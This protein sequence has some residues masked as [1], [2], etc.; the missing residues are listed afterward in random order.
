MRF[1]DMDGKTEV[2]V[3]NALGQKVDVITVDGKSGREV[4]YRMP[5]VPNGLYYLVMKSEK[6]MVIRKLLLQR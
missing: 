5:D 2:Q 1:D 4:D 3:F 6:M